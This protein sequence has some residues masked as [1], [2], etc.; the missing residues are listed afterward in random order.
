M[1][2]VG[3]AQLSRTQQTARR[4][5]GWQ[6]TICHGA[7]NAHRVVSTS[8]L[9]QNTRDLLQTVSSLPNIP[10]D[11]ELRHC[12][13]LDYATSGVLLYARSKEAAAAA[14]QAFFHRKVDKH[15]L[16]VLHGTLQVNTQD[17][18]VVPEE[19]LQVLH[20]H[21]EH[22][23]DKSEPKRGADTFDGFM[24]PHSM[25]QKWSA[26]Y[27]KRMQ[28]NDEKATKRLK[29][30]DRCNRRFR[31]ID[32]TSHDGEQRLVKYRIDR[33]CPLEL[34]AS[35]AESSRMETTLGTTCGFIQWQ[36]AR[37]GTKPNKT[38]SELQ[39][40]FPHCFECTAKPNDSFYIFAP[41]AEVEND[42][43]MRVKP[44]TL[45]TDQTAFEGTFDLDYK[46][47]LTKCVILET[48]CQNGG[49]P[50]TKVRLE[51]KTGRRHQ[52][53]IHMLVA[54]TSILGDATYAPKES[55][56]T[57]PRMCLHAQSLSLPVLGGERLT[58][59]APDP[60]DLD[61]IITSVAAS[62]S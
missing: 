1:C 2:I 39:L 18:P 46:P 13:Q 4:E 36:N 24:P 60:F 21:R 45:P 25:L 15:Y 3:N 61:E 57:Y 6:R 50:L 44:G 10:N 52:L 22:C 62:Q 49:I 8:P 14:Q 28:Q 41:I 16:A 27:L 55:K 34:E 40:T 32:E 51:P 35:Q 42:F 11:L 5:N 56:G 12:H 54:G 48:T 17:W 59:E 37:K 53:R 47:S 38:R 33:A 58:V 26:L 19:R 23:I 29:P 9:F 7:K 43:A 20:Q 31:R 30:S